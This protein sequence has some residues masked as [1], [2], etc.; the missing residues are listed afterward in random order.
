MPTRF[1]H[2]D[3]CPERSRGHCGRCGLVGYCCKEHQVAD[4]ARHKPHCAEARE[5]EA[6]PHVLLPR[7]PASLL[8]ALHARATA[9]APCACKA[10]EDCR[11]YSFRLTGAAASVAE[12]ASVAS[13]PELR[14]AAPFAADL[15]ARTDD[16]PLKD[17]LD[18]LARD[19]G[20]EAWLLELQPADE[21]P[22][23]VSSLAL[24]RR[25]GGGGPGADAGADAR[26][27][28]T[29]GVLVAVAPPGE[30]ARVTALRALDGQR[31]PAAFAACL[32]SCATV[33]VT[34]LPLDNLVFAP[35]LVH[36]CAEA[37]NM[38]RGLLASVGR[39]SLCMHVHPH[40]LL[41]AYW[42]QHRG[43][44]GIANHLLQRAC[45]GGA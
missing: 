13:D 45:P 7:A 29:E 12:L 24:A 35:G 5:R 15:C 26:V 11:A 1:C 18:L 28:G 9:A 10:D 23:W 43:H 27:A 14:A 32:R 41:A 21:R 40:C 4:W 6:A 44:R 19:A 2:L 30:A 38:L 3:S 20:C 22:A 16:A 17:L 39:T 8:R 25:R 31:L 34:P 36:G 33:G 42:A 37:S